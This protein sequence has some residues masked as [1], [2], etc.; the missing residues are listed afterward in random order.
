MTYLKRGRQ[1]LTGVLALALLLALAVG[2]IQAQGPEP[3]EGEMQSQEG[4]SVTAAVGSR[5]PIQGRLTDANGSPLNGSYNIRFR[6]Y[7]AALGGSVVCE[8]TNSVEVINGLFNSEIWGD[9]GS[10]DMN[11][12]QLYLGIKVGTDDEMTDRQAIYPVPYA[13]SLKPRAVIDG[14]VSDDPVLWVR[15]NST[16]DESMGIYAQAAGLSGETYGVYGAS[17]SADGYGGRFFGGNGLYAEGITG[18]GGYFKNVSGGYAL[19]VEGGMEMSV[20]AGST[21]EI[22]VGDRYRDNAIVAWGKISGGDPGS[23][24]AEFGISAVDH[25]NTGCYKIYLDSN[26]AEAASL[27]PMAIAEIDAAPVGAGAIRIVS[28]NQV[29]PGNFNVYINDGNGNLVNND[30]VFIVTAR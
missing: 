14:E 4:A 26:A 11:G 21:K 25:Y 29:Q 19:A 7:N 5:I 1:I 20:N 10:S 22:N 18:Y 3:L 6:L 17:L 16:A 9:C 23:I 24:Q 8:D 28:V 27:I 13:F 2:L 15:N 12:Q 30:F